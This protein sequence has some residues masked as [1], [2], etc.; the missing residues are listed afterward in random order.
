M[1][2]GAPMTTSIP[3]NAQDSERAAWRF[4]VLMAVVAM[5]GDVSYEG[6]RSISGRYLSLLGASATVVA[7]TAGFG[8]LAGSGLRVLTGW[9]ADRTRAY[10]PLTIL[11]YS[12]N[13]LAI[14]T[15]ALCDAWQ[16]AAVLVVL[17]R[18]GKA[19]R[20]PSR[21]VLLSHAADRLGPGKTFGLDELLDQ[22]GAV[23]GPLLLAGAMWLRAG[24]P[25]L[26]RYR[27]AFVVTLVPV[28]LNVAL[29]LFARSR[30]PSPQD[31]APKVAPSDPL[32]AKRAL[33]VYLVAVALLGAAF[34]DWALVAVHV[35]RSSLL[36]EAWVPT[37]YAIAMGLDGAAALVFG[38]AYDR[39]GVRVLSV[40][41][42]ALA[43]GGLLVFT[44]GGL[45]P[46]LAGIALWAIALGGLESIAKAAIATLVPKAERG[47]AYG[48]FYG[49]LGVAWWLGSVALGLAY[50]VDP[51]WCGAITAA[52]GLAA[53]I[54]L[55]RVEAP[56]PAKAPPAM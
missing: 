33:R 54:V 5:L 8:E 23:A 36:D 50:D 40:A 6:A 21:A 1:P 44:V 3:R 53:A 22:I 19:I 4:L 20:S 51:R 14:P 37:L 38:H 13:L 39:R 42:L 29:A 32:H 26:A 27:L 56:A 7:L 11:G 31:F 24:E 47:V 49:V 30:F 15:L 48:R 9:L 34:V 17:E 45:V 2:F 55:F 10:W 25:D 52:L 35:G 16:A 41:C 43:G 18:I 46:M 28:L 12:T